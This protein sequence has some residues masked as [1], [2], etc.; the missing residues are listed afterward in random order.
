[1]HRLW[2]PFVSV[3]LVFCALTSPLVAQQPRVDEKDL[4]TWADRG[5]ADAQFELGLR[6]LTG[7]G[8]KKNDK[9][10]VE[11]IKKAAEQKHVRAQFVLG[12]L[13][14]DGLGVEKSEPKAF[15]WYRKAA[16]NGFPAAQHAAAMAYD[17]GRGV[18]QDPAA[19]AKWLQ[20]AADQDHAPSQTALAAKFERGVGVAKSTAKAALYYLRAAQQDFVPAMSRLA[21]LYYTGQGVPT[22][23]RRAGAWYKRAARSEDPWAANNLSWF[24]ATCPD[25][26]LHNGEQAVQF[27][28]RALKLLGEAGEEQRYEMLDTM[29]A[30]LARNGEFLE[31]VLWQ[32]K[33]LGLLPDDKELA[34]DE[35]KTLETEFQTRLKLYQ[36]QTPFSE[37]EPKA[38]EGTAPLPQD[39]ILEDEGLP[40]SSPKPKKKGAGK[41]TVV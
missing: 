23:L 12:S 40:P 30:A 24:L 36:K 33:A 9:E 8:V 14:E 19:A 17:L 26:S 6:Q 15:E 41:G 25:E 22:D 29:A 21:S 4:R 34:D 39:T 3:A 16:E 31:A 7:E 11:W 38:E 13:Y 5:D 2:S 20:K 27:A 28:K 18:K 37:A 10:G 35:R 1:M 32:K